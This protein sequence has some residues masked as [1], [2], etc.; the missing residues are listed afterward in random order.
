MREN[1]YL[2]RTLEDARAELVGLG[3]DVTV[4]PRESEEPE[5]TVIAISPTGERSPGDSINLVYAVP[6]EEEETVSVPSGLIG[7]SEQEAAAAI[8]SAGLIPVSS[9][10]VA[11]DQPEGTVVSVEPGEGSDVDPGSEV[12]LTISEGP[13][14]SPSPSSTPAPSAS[15][16]ASPSATPS[17]APTGSS[18]TPADG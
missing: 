5:N 9:G 1:E 13:E 12:A 16:E 18:S 6:A 10:S 14:E 15:E 2:G 3:F 8:R 7:Q 4:E 11:S 17:A